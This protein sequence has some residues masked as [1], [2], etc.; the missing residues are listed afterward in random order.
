MAVY[1]T[2]SLIEEAKVLDKASEGRKP[3]YQFPGLSFPAESSQAPS[4]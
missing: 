2:E 3:F 4:H 1:A